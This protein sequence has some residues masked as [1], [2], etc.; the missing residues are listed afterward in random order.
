[1]AGCGE[2]CEIQIHNIRPKGTDTKYGLKNLSTNND[3]S[4]ALVVERNYN[5]RNILEGTTLQVNSPHLLRIFKSIVEYYPAIP[6]D[7]NVPFQMESPFQMLF[8]HWDELHATLDKDDLG[9]EARMHLNL[10]L[11]F[12]K[13]ELGPSKERVSSM[14]KAG[15]ISFSTLWTI[16]RPGC[17]VY[18]E[19]DSH[20]WLLRL[21]KTAYEESKVRGKFLEVHCTYTDYD[22][23]SYGQATNVINIYQKR[24]FAAEN[25]SKITQLP[26]FPLD[27]HE[28]EGLQEQLAE[29]GARFL[30]IRG[31]Q[32]RAYNGLARYLKEPPYSWYDPD[33]GEYPG[34]W[35]PHTVWRYPLTGSQCLFTDLY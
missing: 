7:Y 14:L 1:M 18:T 33:M 28:G 5:E 29:R 8:H 35:L 4:Y 22:G 23:E 6:A 17:L 12:M 30:S 26:V 21:E 3:V 10:L 9:D 19:M 24:L 2:Q 13:A 20:P 16:F 25:P 34:V 11:G 15:A 27:W 31:V 32:V